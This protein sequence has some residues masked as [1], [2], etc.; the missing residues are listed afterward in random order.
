M[1]I[2]GN[3]KGSLSYSKPVLT[4]FIGIFQQPANVDMSETKGTLWAD[5]NE[6]ATKRGLGGANGANHYRIGDASQTPIQFVYEAADCR[7]WY[8]K[9]MFVD[10]LVLWKRVAEIA[11]GPRSSTGAM[12]SQYCV[13]GST[14]H[15][16]S[17][18]GGLKQGQIGPQNPPPMAKANKTGWIIGGTQIVDSFSPAR[19]DGASSK[20]GAGAVIDH[21]VAEVG[22]NALQSLIDACDEYTGDMWFVKL[23]CGK[24]G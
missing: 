6:M 18:S 2:S 17:G 1:Q 24:L 20:D 9:E 15:P 21:S 7:I 23:F 16:T 19:T 22:T 3:T 14:G 10:V 13:Q 11:F 4:N 12:Q 8:T 5:W